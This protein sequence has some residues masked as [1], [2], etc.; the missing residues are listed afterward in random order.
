VSPAHDFKEACR[1]ARSDVKHQDCAFQ[2]RASTA[3]A[4]AV[5]AHEQDIK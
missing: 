3:Q 1:L 5:V 2:N 4:A